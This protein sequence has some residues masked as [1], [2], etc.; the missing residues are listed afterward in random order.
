MIAS[1]GGCEMNGST[2]ERSAARAEDKALLGS[3][4][5]ADPGAKTEGR[6]ADRNVRRSPLPTLLGIGTKAINPSRQSREHA[7]C[8]LPGDG[9]PEI[10]NPER[11]ELHFTLN[12]YSPVE[13]EQRS[14][15]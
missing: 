13:V 7:G 8:E 9:L 2:V 5:S 14:Q 1:Q 6:A 4:P 10:A 12:H 3:N 11:L 15:A